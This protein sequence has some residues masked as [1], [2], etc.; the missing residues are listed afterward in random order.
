VINPGGDEV[1]EALDARKQHLINGAE[2]VKD[3]NVPVDEG[4][5]T[6]VRNDDEGADFIPESLD[7]CFSGWCVDGPSKA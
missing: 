5:K 7:A 4:Q 6:V 1:G 2:G 3:L